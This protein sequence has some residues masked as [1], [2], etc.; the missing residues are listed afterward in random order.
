[1]EFLKATS[2]FGNSLYDYSLAMGYFVGG[3]VVVWVI[4]TV[5][6]GQAKKLAAKTKTQFDDELVLL[7]E[8]SVVPILYY[9]IFYITS[10]S[11][12]QHPTIDKTITVLGAILLTY[13]GVR[14]ILQLARFIIFDLWVPKQSEKIH[15][16]NQFRGLM[17]ALTALVWG[18]GIVFLLGNLGFNISALVTGLGIGGIAVALAAQT[19]LG[20]LF[21]YFSIM[22]DRPFVLG[23]FLIVGDYMGTVEHIGIKTTRLRSLG[24]EQLIFSNKDLTDSRIKNYKRMRERRV[25]F[26]LGVT[27]DTTLKNLK[28]I[29]GLLQKIVEQTPQVKFGRSHFSVFGDFNLEIETVYYVK[30]GDYNEYMDIQQQIN[31]AVKEEFE[32]RK[33][34]FAFPTQT[35][36]NIKQPAPATT[37]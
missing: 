21:A 31:F 27:Y 35:I 18:A 13:F 30:S 11:L 19:V 36:Y 33:I 26:K 23:D 29:P 32:R 5:I 10:K 7:I 3:F 37:N 14:F 17:P 12:N 6:F 2:F 25:V 1:M 16:E 34:E 4:K 20:D 28:E 9:G 8:R 24:G 15:L 22:F